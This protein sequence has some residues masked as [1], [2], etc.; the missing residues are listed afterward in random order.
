[1]QCAPSNAASIG[2]HGV[3]CVPKDAPLGIHGALCVLK[4]APLGMHGVPCVPKNALLRIHS[5]SQKCFSWNAWC[6]MFS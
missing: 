3:P 1:M 4:N 6:S 2:L 5:G